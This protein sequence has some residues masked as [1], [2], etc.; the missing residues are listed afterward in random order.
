MPHVVILTGAGIS[1]ESG[2][3]TFRAPDGDEPAL[4]EEHDI[5]DVATPAGYR[6]NPALVNDFYRARRVAAAV[7]EPNAAHAAIA[8]LGSIIGDQLLVVTQNVDD[9]HERAGL[10]DNLLIHMHGSLRTTRCVDC[11]DRSTGRDYGDTCTV[12]GGGVLRPDVVWFGE[13]PHE[14]GRIERSV[15]EAGM[16]IAIGT[17]GEV[18]PAAGLVDIARVHGVSTVEL[19]LHPTGGQFE[20]ALQGPATRTVPTF[21]DG[22]IGALS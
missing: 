16:F 4:W 20:L 17:S 22:L 12:C 14:M 3:P 15:G 8:R 9:L 21:V 13:R 2:I 6:R 7:A 11:G 10:R 1:A 18:Y 19:N 5:E